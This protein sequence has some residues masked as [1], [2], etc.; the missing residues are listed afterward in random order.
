MSARL[1]TRIAISAALFLC[2]VVYIHGALPLRLVDQLERFTYDARVRLTMPGTVDPRIAIVDIDDK[3]LKEQGQWPLPRDKFATLMDQLF[4]HYHVKL[5]AFDV[6][7]PEADRSF[8]LSLLD[9]LSSGALKNDPAFVSEAGKI[10][11][12][13]ERD[14]IFAAS[15]QHRPVVLGYVFYSAT[16]AHA[17]PVGLLPPPAI[18]GVHGQYPLVAFPKEVGYTTNL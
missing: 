6:S 16:E 12:Q 18:P 11:P 4:D 14:K 5:V 7:F 10:R 1:L 13:I 2:F 17:Q 9:Q 3:T 8:D 15:L